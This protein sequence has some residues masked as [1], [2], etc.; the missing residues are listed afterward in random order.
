MTLLNLPFSVIHMTLNP[1][2]D[3]Y[4][5]WN[6]LSPHLSIVNDPIVLT[7]QILVLTPIVFHVLLL[8]WQQLHGVCDKQRFIVSVR[9]SLFPELI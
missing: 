7:Y 6:S 3:V 5:C 2:Q 4:V 8:E 9:F 1:P